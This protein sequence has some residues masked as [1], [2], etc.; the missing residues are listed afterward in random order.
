MGLS[1]IS[2]GRS[3]APSYVPLS[4]PSQTSI[5]SKLS[6]PLTSEIQDF[7]ISATLSWVQWTLGIELDTTDFQ[8][9]SER[10]K[11]D[12]AACAPL[13]RSKIEE[14]GG[15]TRLTGKFLLWSGFLILSMKVSAFIFESLARFMTSQVQKNLQGFCRQKGYLIALDTTLK[16]LKGLKDG[17]VGTH[18]TQALN[19]LYQDSGPAPDLK[20]MVRAFFADLTEVFRDQPMRKFFCDQAVDWVFYPLAQKKVEAFLLDL[21]KN[22]DQLTAQCLKKINDFL[23]LDQE[24]NWVVVPLDQLPQE[25]AFEWENLTA[26]SLNDEWFFLEEEPQLQANSMEESFVFVKTPKE[27]VNSKI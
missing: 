19:K 3:S 9:L 13:L 16:Q 23:S 4:F 6:H 7:S 15:I 25:D 22:P 5:H 24:D 11:R 27:V 10:G 21:E 1:L 26:P 17:Q 12:L 8:V 18:L 14:T 20:P 2:T